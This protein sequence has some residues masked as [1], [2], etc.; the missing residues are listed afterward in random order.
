M[1]K[2]TQSQGK[3]ACK[4]EKSALRKELINQLVC[5]IKENDTPSFVELLGC[6]SP[7]ISALA[8]SFN[9]P[10]SEFED[11]CQEG[12]MALYRAAMSYDACCAEFSTYATACMTNAMISFA[13]KYRADSKGAVLNEQGDA[14]SSVE[15]KT[16]CP[17]Q[18]AIANEL[19]GLLSV[20]G[21]AGLSDYERYVTQLKLSGLM[22]RDIAKM[23]G[24]SAK[25]IDNTLFRA[26][27]KLKKHIDR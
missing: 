17:I 19:S 18:S 24:K 25:S 7:S 2:S 15:D 27:Q 12:R 20:S 10:S 8:R 14:A 4:S 5:K 3:S 6:F 11:L 13:N 16:A 21:F 26:R 1:E 22:T 9:L 23:T